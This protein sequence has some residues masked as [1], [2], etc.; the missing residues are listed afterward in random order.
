[1]RDMINRVPIT[2]SADVPKWAWGKN[3][4]FSVKSVYSHMCASD[5]DI[6]HKKYLQS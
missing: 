4:L 2:E 1:M 6:S 5:V 3:G